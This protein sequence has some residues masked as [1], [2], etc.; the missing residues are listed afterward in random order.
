MGN[1]EWGF[2]ITSK[3]G[4]NKILKMVRAHNSSKKYGED[5]E[6][7]SIIKHDEDNKYYLCICNGGGAEQTSEFITSNYADLP[8]V[9]F[10]FEKPDWWNDDTKYSTFWSANSFKEAMNPDKFIV[11]PWDNI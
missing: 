11:T 9:Y 4:V 10:P 6:V 3:K 7:C 2:L 1:R 5:L 8:N